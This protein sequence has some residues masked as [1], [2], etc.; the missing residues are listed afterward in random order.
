MEEDTA[1]RGEVVVGADLI[2]PSGITLTI[3]AGTVVKFLPQEEPVRILVLGRLIARG[4]QEEILFTSSSPQPQMGDWWGIEFRASDIGSILENCRIEYARYG[5]FCLASSPHVKRSIISQN[6][7]G[8]IFCINRSAPL[9][10]GCQIWGNG[11]E[12]ILCKY[13]SDPVVEGTKITHNPYG[14]VVLDSSNPFLGSLEERG[15]N[16]IY[17][18]LG[19]DIYNLSPWR[20][21]AQGNHWKES[22]PSLIDQRIYDDDEDSSSGEVLFASPRPG[23]EGEEPAQDES[24]I[25]PVAMLDSLPRV[26]VRPP[27][28][29]DV[30]CKGKVVVKA[31]VDEE[32]WVSQ[33][34]VERSE[35]EGDCEETAVRFVR[36]WRFSPG[37]CQGERSLFW[38]VIPIEFPGGER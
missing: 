19:F 30:E 28:P 8:G 9:V 22:Q 20:I 38:A 10:E 21:Q 11:G 24:S 13:L 3:A 7:R 27:F 25:V 17:D 4:Q 15:E 35:L 5:L 16:Q 6:L 34:R 18:N 31:W 29:S 32:G 1:W 12:G 37:T 33:A 14:V 2:I 26:L 23:R 36:G